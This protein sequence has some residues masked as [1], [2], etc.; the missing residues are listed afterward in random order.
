MPASLIVNG[1][2]IDVAA[3]DS[4]FDAAGRAG[5][6]IPTSCVTQGKCRECMVEVTEGMSLLSP[7]TAPERHLTGR[8]RLSCQSGG[9]T[10]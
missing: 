1:R 7:P 3:G 9:R 2:R 8:F 10:Y 6:R 5:I 4:L